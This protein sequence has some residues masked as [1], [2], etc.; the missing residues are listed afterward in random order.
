MTTLGN[1]KFGGKYHLINGQT[2]K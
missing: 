1:G 2:V